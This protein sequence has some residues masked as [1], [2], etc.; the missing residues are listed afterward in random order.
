MKTT[1]ATI[2]YILDQLISAGDV[3]ARKMFG[4]YALYCDGKVVALVCR[5]T[6]F[7]KITDEGKKFVGKYYHEGHAYKGARTSMIIDDSRIEDHEWLSEL[8]RITADNLPTPKQKKAV[9]K[10]PSR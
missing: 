1:Q 7:V 4:E 10:S 8:I 3:A 9:K 6:L 5:N 2:D